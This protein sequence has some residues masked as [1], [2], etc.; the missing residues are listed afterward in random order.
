MTM[1]KSTMDEDV[2]ALENEMFLLD[3]GIFRLSS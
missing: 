2:F 3:M 1:E